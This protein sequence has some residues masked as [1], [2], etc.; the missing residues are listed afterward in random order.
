MDSPAPG[1]PHATVYSDQRG[2]NLQSG[3]PLT[4][5]DRLEADRLWN[6]MAKPGT[7]PGKKVEKEKQKSREKRNL[8]K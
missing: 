2:Y 1:R 6:L 4:E 5:E 3:T 8:N 7:I